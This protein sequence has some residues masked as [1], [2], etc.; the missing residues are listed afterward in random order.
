MRKLTSPTLT[1]C[2][3]EASNFNKVVMVKEVT[4]SANFSGVLIVSFPETKQ[5]MNE[6]KTLLHLE[7]PEPASNQ[8]EWRFQTHLASALPCNNNKKQIEGKWIG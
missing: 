4:Q 2:L 5:R 1:I 3:A 8:K 7:K 6:N